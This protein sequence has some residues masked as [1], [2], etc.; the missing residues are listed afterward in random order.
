MFYKVKLERLVTVPPDKLDAALHRHL[1]DFLC[2]AVVGQLMPPPVSANA[3]RGDYR[4]ATKSS[5]IVLAVTDI[6]KERDRELEGKVLDNG[7]VAF[8]LCYEAL[9]LK[10]HRGEVV[11]VV[12]E[13]VEPEGWWGSVY[14][15][16][17][18]FVSKNQMSSTEWEYDSGIAEGSWVSVDGRQSIKPNQLV[19]IRVLEETPQS[20]NAMVI[21][22]MVGSYLGPL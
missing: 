14:G 22:T 15:A 5:A 10:L 1:L 17:K 20:V 11:D 3:M 18:A 6:L 2:K 13:R 16:G 21:G 19:R 8:A 9:V 7:S 4:S 12:V